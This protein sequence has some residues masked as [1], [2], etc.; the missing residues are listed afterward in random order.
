MSQSPSPA[1]T[2]GFTL[3]ETMVAMVILSVTAVT[4]A[5]LMLRSARTATSAA[6]SV[7]QNAVLSTEVG[8]L[9]ALPF[10]SLPT[11]TTCVTVTTPPLPHTR[12]TTVNSISSKVHEFIVIIT[13]SGNSLLKPDTVRFE[14]TKASNGSPLNTP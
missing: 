14:R 7:H 13:P 11:G 8:R 5:P 10:D 9:G 6:A 1:A 3:I 12:C 4:L 2:G